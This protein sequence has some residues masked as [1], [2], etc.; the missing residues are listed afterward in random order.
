MTGGK[1]EVAT[2]NSVIRPR[3]KGNSRMNCKNAK[4]L[5]EHLNGN[6]NLEVGISAMTFEHIF[7][8]LIL[9]DLEVWPTGT[10][11]PFS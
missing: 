1:S 6:I 4:K 2:F 11:R 3:M 10:F 8:N 5:I 7:I 9:S